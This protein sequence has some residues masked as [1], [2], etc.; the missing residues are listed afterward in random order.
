ML[1]HLQLEALL[2][3][4]SYVIF[5]QTIALRAHVHVCLMWRNVSGSF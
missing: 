2:A 3:A 1:G 5:K 4:D